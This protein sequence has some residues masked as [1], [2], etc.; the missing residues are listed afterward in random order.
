MFIKIKNMF[1]T[2]HV[3]FNKINSLHLNNKSVD[4]IDNG[5]GLENTDVK[6]S[7]NG[8][9][10]VC[11]P[12]DVM[13]LFSGP[14]KSIQSK[15]FWRP[16]SRRERNWN[17]SV[18]KCC[19]MGCW[20]DVGWANYG[21]EHLLE[22][23]SFLWFWWENL[24]KS[25]KMVNTGKPIGGLTKLSPPVYVGICWLNAIHLLQN[26]SEPVYLE[27]EYAVGG[28]GMNAMMINHGIRGRI[29]ANS[30]TPACFDDFWSCKS[31][32]FVI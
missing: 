27:F 30:L 9:Q 8:L 17:R 23:H 15:S 21:W 28:V 13:T 24:W 6:T 22:S 5:V 20:V 29:A 12:E 19:R 10:W 16:R 18:R 32:N 26:L 3:H 1:T 2:N 31:Q 4:L 7:P 11:S 14:C 25:S